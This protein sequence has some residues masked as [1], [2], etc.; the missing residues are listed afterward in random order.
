[1]SSDLP[2]SDVAVT[3]PEDAMRLITRYE[4]AAVAG[5]PVVQNEW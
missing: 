1:M 3:V 5:G 4:L 2:L